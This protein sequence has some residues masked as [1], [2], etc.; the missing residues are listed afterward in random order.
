V[1]HGTSGEGLG[2]PATLVI[3]AQAMGSASRRFFERDAMNWYGFTAFVVCLGAVLYAAGIDG[4]MRE[5]LT[6][7][8]TSVYATAPLILWFA[9]WLVW[10]L[11]R[12][13]KSAANRP[14][15]DQF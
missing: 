7:L 14:F 11:Y 1:L 3:F 2:L 5:P 10:R 15:G 9:L 4:L 8:I 6:V 12:L 13:R